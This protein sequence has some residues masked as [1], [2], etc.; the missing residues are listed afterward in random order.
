MRP[1]VHRALSV[2]VLAVAIAGPAA[3]VW[4]AEPDPGRGA[5]AAGLPQG[6]AAD[7]SFAGGPG[8]ALARSSRNPVLLDSLDQGYA[9]GYGYGQGYA[10]AY[11]PAY[12]PGYAPALDPMLGQVPPLPPVPEPAS[13]YGAS[14]T[15]PPGQDADPQQPSRDPLAQVPGRDTTDAAPGLPSRA[16]GGTDGESGLPP[17]GTGEQP[18]R[19]P[20]DTADSADAGDG[21]DG[22]EHSDAA[23]QH[24][25]EAGAGGSFGASLPALVGGGALIA[26][27]VG[28]AA[29][30]AWP[31][32]R[33]D[34]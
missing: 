12:A 20:A 13:P 16:P 29:H 25:V 28:A 27:A 4:A 10:P 31:R 32:R 33:A 8:A 34:C 1:A 30:R 14:R 22:A 21:G 6:Y 17:R 15:P 18:G 11:A 3:P 5:G 2:A 9:Y 19:G 26:A 23:V 24:G 7:P